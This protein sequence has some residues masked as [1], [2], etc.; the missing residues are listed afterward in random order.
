MSTLVKV[1]VGMRHIEALIETPVG[2][3]KPPLSWALLL[4]VC[5]AVSAL[6]TLGGAHWLVEQVSVAGDFKSELITA[7]LGLGLVLVGPV[8]VLALAVILPSWWFRAMRLRIVR[9]IARGTRR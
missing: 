2:R 3:R 1:D 5:I 9:M 7:V 4:I 6:L 8:L